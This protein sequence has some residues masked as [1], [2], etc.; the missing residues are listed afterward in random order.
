[1]DQGA[2][3]QAHQA[4]QDPHGERRYQHPHPDPARD[5]PQGHP[6]GVS[7][8]G[9]RGALLQPVLRRDVLLHAA[10]TR[11]GRA[12]LHEGTQEERRFGGGQRQALRQE[13]EEPEKNRGRLEELYPQARHQAGRLEI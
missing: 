11:K 10:L 5:P 12:E 8:Q 3:P 7:R 1:Q 2:Q 9:E 4:R 6:R 13:D